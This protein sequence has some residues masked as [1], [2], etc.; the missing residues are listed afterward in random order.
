MKNFE[1]FSEQSTILTNAKI[2]LEDQV[3]QGS[4][5]IKEGNISEISDGG[6]SAKNIIDCNGDYLGPGL[7]ELHT[8]NLERHLQPRPGAL[9]PRKAAILSHDS[10]L[11]SV[12]ITTV[13]NALRV[14]S[15][16]SKKDSN[17][18]KYARNVADDILLMNAG[19]L[20]RVSHF[21]HLRAEVC[22]ETL[23]EEMSEFSLAD[24]IG[25]VSIM[26]HTPGQRQFR[27]ITKMKEYLVGK[28]N[29]TPAQMDAY[30]GH[31]YDLREQYGALHE[32]GAERIGKN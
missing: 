4:L 8:D 22:S 16:I 9:W 12:G 7:V 24:R 15:I 13:F 31:L 26:D 3:V 29:M 30:I 21:L 1:A 25:I 5:V 17:Y 19:N 10:E 32:N 11:A 2:I 28:Y 23:L 6:T 20:L 18:K 14:G 27:K